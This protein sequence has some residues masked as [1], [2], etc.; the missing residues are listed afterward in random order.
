M[1]PIRKTDEEPS[2]PVTLFRYTESTGWQ[3]EVG[4]EESGTDI[5]ASP[6]KDW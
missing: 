4:S 2:W 3:K 1:T 6:R 5:R